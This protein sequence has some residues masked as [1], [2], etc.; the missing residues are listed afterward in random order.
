MKEVR[1]T[2]G[3]WFFKNKNKEQFD[4]AEIKRYELINSKKLGQYFTGNYHSKAIFTSRSL[5][6]FISEVSSN[7]STSAALFYDNQGM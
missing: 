6:P 2:F 3:S 5:S 1:K 7:N 4:Q